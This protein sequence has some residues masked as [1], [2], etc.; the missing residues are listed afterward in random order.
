MLLRECGSH[1]FFKYFD[2]GNDPNVI[3]TPTQRINLKYRKNNMKKAISI[4][5]T[6][7]DGL[8]G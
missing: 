3:Y 5:W 6:I 8:C 2:I 7:M 1:L 4:E